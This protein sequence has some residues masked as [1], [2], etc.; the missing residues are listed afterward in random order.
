M[1]S[2]GGMRCRLYTIEH[3][4]GAYDILTG[5]ELVLLV[6]PENGSAIE[7]FIHILYDT[8]LAFTFI[9]LCCVKMVMLVVSGF[10]HSGSTSFTH[11]TQLSESIYCTSSSLTLACW[12]SKLSLSSSAIIPWSRNKCIITLANCQISAG[13]LRYDLRWASSNLLQK[14]QPASSH[15]PQPS[16]RSIFTTISWRPFSCWY[17]EAG[18]CVYVKLWS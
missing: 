1:D 3:L 16:S 14:T 8:S 5:D 10:I 2:L 17:N 15:Q 13:E 6:V 4:Q 12:L 7:V 11:P 18:P 9:S